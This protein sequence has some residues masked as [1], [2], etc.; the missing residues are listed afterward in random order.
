MKYEFGLTNYFLHELGNNLSSDNSLFE[1]ENKMFD[2]N[3][4]EEDRINIE[5]NKIKNISD[6]YN[7][8][9]DN[10]KDNIKDIIVCIDLLLGIEVS[11]KS[12][13]INISMDI[14]EDDRL[15]KIYDI[16]TDSYEDTIKESDKILKIVIKEY[17]DRIVHC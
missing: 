12:N 5:I 14:L 1:N 6:K 15:S 9:L 8:C 13:F 4:N 10:N 11:F 7:K 16:E 3:I 2:S 17:L